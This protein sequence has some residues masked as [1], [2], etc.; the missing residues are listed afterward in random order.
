M[1]IN[2]HSCFALEKFNSIRF[3]PFLNSAGFM[4][5]G[6]AIN[7]TAPF[8]FCPFCGAS[9]KVVKTLPGK[10]KGGNGNGA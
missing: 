1:K 6:G 3:A 5:C 10:I 4:Q 2:G 8:H 7:T 9:F